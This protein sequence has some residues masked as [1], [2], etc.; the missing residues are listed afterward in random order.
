[1][2]T[3]DPPFP[4]ADMW[5]AILERELT[6]APK[7][8]DIIDVPAELDELLGD[9]MATNPDDRPEHMKIVVQ[10]IADAKQAFESQSLRESTNIEAPPILLRP[11]EPSEV[12]EASVGW[13]ADHVTDIV[14]GPH[15][16]GTRGAAIGFLDQELDLHVVDPSRNLLKQIP[17][18]LD[19]PPVA[20][21]L[22]DQGVM[23]LTS[24]REVVGFDWDGNRRVIRPADDAVTCIGG[25]P[26]GRAII[27]LKTGECLVQQPNGSWRGHR[28]G[29]SA[30]Q[31]IAATRDAV[32]IS[33]PDGAMLVSALSFD[34]PLM[35]LGKAADGLGFSN[36]S[37]LLGVARNGYYAVQNVGN[38]QMLSDGALPV[39][40]TTVA[41]HKN[42]LC[43]YVV[44][45]GRL[46]RFRLG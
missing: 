41:F 17:T 20:I 9:M 11:A 10:R 44:D 5:E 26:D 2:L 46:L 23:L 16:L 40:A 43:A 12:T 27:G 45:S 37:Y 34:V 6:E 35:H 4:D 29:R 14:V 24:D 33:S 42:S 30:I 13:D 3:G 18:K 36:D 1:M 32:A 31:L 19:R 15:I 22:W 39:G 8:S 7:V 38:R 25:F 21:Q 28:A